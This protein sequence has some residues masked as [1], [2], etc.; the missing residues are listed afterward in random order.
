MSFTEEMALKFVQKGIRLRKQNV[1][2]AREISEE[3]N[4]GE[5]AARVLAARG[6]KPDPE[7]MNFINPTLKQGLPDP[8]TLKNVGPACELIASI[9][10]SK[11]PIAIC[12]DFDVDGLSGGAQLAHFL[13]AVGGEVHVY[14]PDR[15]TDG[16]G[17]NERIIRKA[18]QDG[19]ALLI[20]VDF[21]TRNEKEVGLARSL[22]MRTLII[23]H[24]HVGDADPKADVFINPQQAG[25]GFANKILCAAGLVW[26][27]IIALK[28]RIAAAREIDVKSYL[29]F[30]CLG[31]IC[32]MVPLVGANRVIAKRGL[33]ALAHTRRPGLKALKDVVGVRSALTCTHVS[34]G[35][36]PRLNAAGRMVHGEVVA[37]LLTTADSDKAAKLAKQLNKLN[38]ERQGI[39]A[40]VKEQAIEIARQKY[41]ECAHSIVVWQRDFHTG[42]IGIVAQRLVENFYRPSVVLGLDTDGVFKGSVRGIRGFSVVEALEATNKFL[43]KSGGHEGAGGL[44]I[45]EARLEDFA[46]AFEVECAKRLK[47]LEL[48]PFA[49][50]DTQVTLSELDTDL[51]SELQN[52]APFGM[53]NPGP[54][55]LL[56]GLKV[57]DLKVLK[58]AHLKATLSDGKR[59]IAGMLWRTVHH[60]ALVIGNKVNVVC[61]ADSNTFNGLTE[62]QANIQAAEIAA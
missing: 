57:V 35:I 47:G 25:C 28:K 44:A 7:L 4:L 10:I 2:L 18:A 20:A 46:A 55:L 45:E 60:P 11:R 37:D 5:V 6:Y 48:H 15:F 26:F 62:V 29:D 52:F 30:A 27:L 14:V 42:V 54:Q 8:E 40:L 21:G 32:D 59:Y 56:N 1:N 23:D 34:F 58:Q 50:A 41:Q 49:E 61:K 24:H 31:T 51:V 9:L 22:G 36:G 17:L 43:I 12:C 13:R 33:E 19:C 16:Y 38:E 39:E 53:G 3:F